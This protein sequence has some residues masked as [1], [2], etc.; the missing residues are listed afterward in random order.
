MEM[1]EIVNL[2]AM[3]TI[4]GTGSAAGILLTVQFGRHRRAELQ[5]DSDRFAEELFT[6]RERARA[7]SRGGLG[8]SGVDPRDSLPI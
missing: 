4:F 7:S 3:L 2:V 6:A 5:A 1:T 8:P